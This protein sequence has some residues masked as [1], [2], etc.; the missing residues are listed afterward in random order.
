MSKLELVY[1][2]RMR[3]PILSEVTTDLP[4]VV[5][6]ADTGNAVSIEVPELAPPVGRSVLEAS[7]RLIMRVSRECTE[8]E[9]AI[10]SNRRDMVS[11]RFYEDL[12]RA[13]WMF[14][15][16]VRESA[17]R[18]SKTVPPYPV[19]PTEFVELNPLVRAT[20]MEWFHGGKA[21]LSGGSAKG[22]PVIHLKESWWA[23]AVAQL[24]TAS[25]VPVY[26]RFALDAA[27]FAEHDPIRAIVM[28]CAA[29]ET[30]LRY[31]LENVA[32]NRDSAYRLA[33]ELRGIPQLRKFAET[34]KGSP[35]FKA[36]IEAAQGARRQFLQECKQRMDNLPILR[37]KLVHQGESSALIT[38][39]PGTTSAVLEAIEWLFASSPQP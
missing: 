24:Q 26:T 9:D 25:L 23:D 21:I 22:I 12:A 4:V 32:S 10:V 17:M 13:I 30:A 38:Q 1:R 14:F 34:A 39:A 11:F 35:L 19:V 6:F 5:K 15:E 7:D 37:N 31:Y 29:W 20:E 28:A 33:A 18:R 8:E 3:Y 16:A 2:I 36:E 27:Y